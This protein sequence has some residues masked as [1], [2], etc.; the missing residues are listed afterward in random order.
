M[1]E[2]LI[3]MVVVIVAV[4]AGVGGWW[5]WQQGYFKPTPKPLIEATIRLDNQCSVGDDVFIVTV[6]E[7]GRS[8]R[9]LNKTAV[10]KLPEGSLVQLAASP[11]YPA[12]AYDGIPQRVAPEMVLTADCS[13]SPRLDGI[14]SSMK[15]TFSE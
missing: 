4:V 7:L 9:F 12:V 13:L 5:L 1:K 6:Q 14:F 2:L 11:D 8:K 10:M 3:L 15:Q